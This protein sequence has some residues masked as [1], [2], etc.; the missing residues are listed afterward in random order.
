MKYITPTNMLQHLKKI[1]SELLVYVDRP[2]V[3]KHE[4]FEI[5]SFPQHWPTTAG[6]HDGGAGCDAFITQQTYVL[7]PKTSLDETMVFFDGVYAYS[8]H[9]SERFLEDLKNRNMAGQSTY[10]ERYL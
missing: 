8:V 3:R 7:I 9:E 6:G 2:L 1:N 10:R 5:I 4:D